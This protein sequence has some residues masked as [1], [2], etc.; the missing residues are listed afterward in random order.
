MLYYDINTLTRKLFSN[1]EIQKFDTGVISR[2]QYVN[3][4][5][6]K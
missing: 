6:N 1:D 5:A 4:L 3:I 2:F